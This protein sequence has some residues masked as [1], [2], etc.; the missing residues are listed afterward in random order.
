MQQ[1]LGQL[2]SGLIEGISSAKRAVE[3]QSAAGG[4]M[5]DLTLHVGAGIGLG[6]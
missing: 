2:Y 1:C 5:T 6:L 3:G 4:A